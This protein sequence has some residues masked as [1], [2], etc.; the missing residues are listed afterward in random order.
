MNRDALPLA[1]MAADWALDAEDHLLALQS[2][3]QCLPDPLE[4]EDLVG[5]TLFLAST[6]S[7][8]MTGQALVV[9]GGVVVTG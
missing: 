2:A 8:A 5:A 4:P 6:L 9:D 3:R 7:K 1:W